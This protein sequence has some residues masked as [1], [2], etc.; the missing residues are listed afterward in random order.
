[1]FCHLA[2]EGIAVLQQQNVWCRARR[3]WCEN[4]L[5][6]H[7]VLFA[8][9]RLMIDVVGRKQI[10]GLHRCSDQGAQTFQFRVTRIC[11]FFSAKVPDLHHPGLFF[12]LI[13]TCGKCFLVHRWDANA[14]IINSK[15][16]TLC[17]IDYDWCEKDSSKAERLARHLILLTS[18]GKLGRQSLSGPLLFPSL[19]PNMH[20][21]QGSGC[22][23]PCSAGIGGPDGGIWLSSSGRPNVQLDPEPVEVQGKGKGWQNGG[24]KEGEGGGRTDRNLKWLARVS[25]QQ[26]QTGGEAGAEV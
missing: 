18:M 20:L 3:W 1:M 26:L 12:S 14:L 9:K 25:Q 24:P 19:L 4:R 11:F 22:T 10:P 21:D 23:F 5:S 16:I 8:E 17:Y 7:A 2:M 13:H 6:H 15:I